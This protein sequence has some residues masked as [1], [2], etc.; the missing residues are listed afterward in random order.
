MT[1]RTALFAGIAAAAL[2]LQPSAAWSQTEAPVAAPAAPAAP[3]PYT[4]PSAPAPA[5]TT[6]PAET[7]P[8]PAPGLAPADA[9][10][11]PAAPAAPAATASAPTTTDDGVLAA[12]QALPLP[13]EDVQIVGPW[14]DGDKSGVWRTVML[15]V[16]PPE[17]ESYRFFIQQ[18]EKSAATTNVLSTTEIKEIP[19]IN[20][21]IVGYRAD[22]P[23][24]GD[25]T[26]LTLFF[27][28]VPSDGEISE[29][30]ELHYFKDQPYTFGPATN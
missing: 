17:K 30:Y 19:G 11:T 5:E 6:A 18:L 12:V 13:I 10:A 23:T 25:T 14:T 20:G 3:A 7:P 29:T 27:D 9:A 4:P 24:E 21:A 22:E 2:S 26:G 1:N 28:I 16:G 8:E 15:Q